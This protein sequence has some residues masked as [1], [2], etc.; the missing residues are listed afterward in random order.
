MDGDS[1]VLQEVLADLKMGDPEKVREILVEMIDYFEL[2][3]YV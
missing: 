3:I 1:K 2:D